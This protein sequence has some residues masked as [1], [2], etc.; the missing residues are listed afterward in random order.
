MKNFMLL[1]AFVFSIFATAQH[2]KHEKLTPSQRATLHAKKMQLALDLTDKQAYELVEI[3]KSNPRPER[4]KKSE[5][6]TAEGKYQNHLNR[7]DQ[8]LAI[9]KEIKGVLNDAQFETWKRIQHSKKNR[10]AHHRKDRRP[11]HRNQKH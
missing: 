7:L 3:F 10:M 4:P 8:Q 9:Q 2:E 11:I 1:F 6:H 5:E